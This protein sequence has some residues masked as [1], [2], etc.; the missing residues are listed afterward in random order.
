MSVIMTMRVQGDPAQFERT[1]QEQAD[2]IG[3]IVEI[4]KGHG[5]IAHRFYGAEGEFM[6]ID[7]WPEPEDFQAF[8]AEAEDEIGPLMQAA[9]VTSEPSVT[10]W[11]K[12]DVGDDVGWDA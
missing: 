6:A 1:A 10:F 2:A 4:A 7:E 8:F 11:R 12:L 5:L 3:R 9:G